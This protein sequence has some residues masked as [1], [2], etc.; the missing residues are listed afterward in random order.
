MM[1]SFMCGKKDNPAVNVFMRTDPAAMDHMCSDQGYEAAPHGG[2]DDATTSAPTTAA[3]TTAAADV[4]AMSNCAAFSFAV[5]LF[6]REF[7]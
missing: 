4:D 6:L 3:P 1:W 2:G 5:I 7:F